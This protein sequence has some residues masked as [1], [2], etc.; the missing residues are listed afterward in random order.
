MKELNKK[1][2]NILVCNHD[3]L[4]S[5]DEIEKHEDGSITYEAYFGS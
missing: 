1:K 3:F 4:E 5:L 2:Y